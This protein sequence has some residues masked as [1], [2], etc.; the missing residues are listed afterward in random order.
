[1]LYHVSILAHNEASNLCPCLSSLLSQSLD[2]DDGI[3]I[4][5][6]ANGCTDNTEDIVRAFHRQDS[7]VSLFSIKDAGKVN[8]LKMYLS[9]QEHALSSQDHGGVVYFMD[10]DVTLQRS[11]TLVQ[12][13]HHLISDSALY[14]VSA[15]SIP[16]SVYNKN[17]DFVSCL[18]RAQSKISNHLK[19]NVMRGAFYCI[20]TAIIKRLAFP[21]N[22]ISD[23]IYFEICLD[24]HFATDYDYPIVYRLHKGIKREIR[25]NLLHCL[26]VLQAYLYLK[27]NA[28]SRLD[29]DS[30]KQRYR[31]QYIDNA[32]ATRYLFK[33]LDLK[34]LCFM[35]IYALYYKHNIKKARRLLAMHGTNGIDYHNFWKT[36][37]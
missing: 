24:G 4:V 33:N 16:E 6:I 5:V 22:L 7:R 2:T 1:M 31:A 32:D 18:F 27:Q 15:S 21:A 17:I 20:K 23:D 13:R 28:F 12:L 35:A 36:R 8:A 14:A 9:S 26:G 30:A 34:S 10:A 3:E 37:D 29:P 19:P 25:R 11:R